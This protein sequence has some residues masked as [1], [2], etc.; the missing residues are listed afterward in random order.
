MAS[1]NAAQ[2]VSLFTVILMVS[3]T[4]VL[5][6]RIS[7][8][9]N[10]EGVLVGKGP[11]VSVGDTAHDPL[12]V[13]LPVSVVMESFLQACASGKIAEAPKAA[14]NP[15]LR[16][17]FRSMLVGFGNGYTKTADGWGDK[18]SKTTITSILTHI[19]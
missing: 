10:V 11:A 12:P 8:F 9:T 18:Q 7:A 19:G 6:D 17:F 2:S 14:I 16:N 1:F 13:P 15:F 5:S 3:A 4:P